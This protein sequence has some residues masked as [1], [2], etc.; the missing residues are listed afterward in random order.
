MA[1]HAGKESRGQVLMRGVELAK[2]CASR[3]GQCADNGL[4]ISV[5]ADTVIRLVPPLIMTTAE[6]DEVVSILCPLIKQLL[7]DAA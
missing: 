7:L 3:V 2:T 6:A 1:A 5:T 4:L